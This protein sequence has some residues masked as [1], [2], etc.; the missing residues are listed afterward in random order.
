MVDPHY[1]F[2]IRRGARQ[3]ADFS[4][5]REVQPKSVQSQRLLHGFER[6]FWGGWPRW[7]LGYG[8]DFAGVT[9]PAPADLDPIWSHHAPCWALFFVDEGGS[10]IFPHPS[11]L[12]SVPGNLSGLNR[13]RS[14]KRFFSDGLKCPIA[15]RLG[16]V[17]PRQRNFRSLPLPWVSSPA[18]LPNAALRSPPNM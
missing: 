9:E 6:L 16:E 2:N 13:L 11:L 15:R 8:M 7:K 12:S 14:G 1:K 5:R 10:R 17:T 18:H 4:E 3:R